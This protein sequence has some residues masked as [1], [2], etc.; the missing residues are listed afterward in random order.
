MLNILIAEGTPAVWQGERASFG[1]PSNFSLFAAAVRLHCPDIRCTR[2]NIADGEALPFG[3]TLS[4]FDGVM[5]PGS[6]L[7]IYDPDPCVT[8]QIDF[9]RAAFAAGVPVWGS[10]WGLQLAVVALGG[11]VRRNPRGREL[12]IARAI[13]LTEA[14]GAHPLLASRPAVF[15][16][17]CSHLDEIE[18]V[19]PN[20]QVLAANEVSAIQAIA[21]QT[22]WS[23]S[24]QGTQYH[25]EHTLA[26]SAALIEMR[27]AE[28][29][30]E[31]FG[32]ES[33]EIVAIAADYR[34][35][36]QEPRRRDLIW[37]YGIA[38]EIMDPVRRTTE[39]GNWLRTVVAPRRF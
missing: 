23:G 12:P 24:F 16:A 28:L 25:P 22:P 37:R 14:G 34:A 1:L 5:F 27:A 20:S 6:P 36:A 8:R 38:S 13:T 18:A 11:S 15:D 30:E 7:H 3:I 10:C 2:L 32:T 21:V 35:L 9:T 29:V 4:D 31:G 39:I 26:V 33:S 17:L 19:P